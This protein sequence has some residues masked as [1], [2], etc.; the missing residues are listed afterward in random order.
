LFI[1]LEHGKLI[2]V[3]GNKGSVLEVVSTVSLDEKHEETKIKIN[4]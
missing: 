1:E 3:Y 4:M 2:I